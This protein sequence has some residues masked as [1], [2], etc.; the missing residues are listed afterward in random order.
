MDEND[1][2]K[3]KSSNVVEIS[4]GKNLKRKKKKDKYTDDLSA[5]DRKSKRLAEMADKIDTGVTGEKFHVV[6]MA[7]GSRH[8]A[9]ELKDKVIEYVSK[10]HVVSS[11]LTYALDLATKEGWSVPT[12][13]N[14]AEEIIEK[15]KLTSKP[16]TEPKKVAFLSDPAMCFKRLS[17]DYDPDKSDYHHPTW[18]KLMS[19]MSC[20]V[21]SFMCFIG[22]LFVEEADRQTYLWMVGEG[23]DGKGSVIRFL[24]R[25]FGDGV[26]VALT[27]PNKNTAKDSWNSSLVGKK[28]GIFAECSNYS[29]PAQGHFLSLSGGDSIPVN[30]KYVKPY[31]IRNDMRFIFASNV[32]PSID[33]SPAAQ[34]RLVLVEF[35]NSF[36]R[37][38]VVDPNFEDKL[39]AEAHSFINRCMVYYYDKYPKHT[40]IVCEDQEVINRLSTANEAEFEDFFDNNFGIEGEEGIDDWN[41]RYKYTYKTRSPFVTELVNRRF[42]KHQRKLFYAWMKRRK[43]IFRKSMKFG[44]ET[45][46]GFAVRIRLPSEPT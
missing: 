39:F 7:D 40:A 28:I 31:T 8:I 21:N 3:D 26:C 1:L 45:K 30:P 6:L 12:R 41:G 19:N 18:D 25:V 43:K 11:Y 5:F 9:R 29:F 46:E 24:E 44:N 10:E 14:E 42:D 23:G 38:V 16:I 4:E 37:V 27:T 13:N 2:G 35:K 32:E 15:F 33:S 34:R 36:D 17:F 22:S 20:N